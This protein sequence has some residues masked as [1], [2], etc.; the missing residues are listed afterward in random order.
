LG[1]LAV[2]IACAAKEARMATTAGDGVV[3]LPRGAELL[4]RRA[5]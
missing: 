3:R 2:L 5:A 1:I 4:Q